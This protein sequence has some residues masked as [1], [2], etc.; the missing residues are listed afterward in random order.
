MIGIYKI[1]N[2]ING[3][4]YIGQS[5]NIEQRF[6]N[7]RNNTKNQ[8]LKNAIKKYGL[9]N[10]E[11]CV[12][13]EIDLD[14][15]TQRKMD[16][17]ENIYIQTYDSSNNKKGYNKKSGGSNGKPTE[18]TK[19]KMR[20]NHTD[21]SGNKNPMYG[22]S[23][24]FAPWYGRK[25]TEEEKLKISLSNKGKHFNNGKPMLN[26]KHTQETKN[27]ISLINKG[28]KHPETSKKIICITT[29]EVFNSITDG[30]NKYKIDIS[31]LAKHCK[32]RNN[33]CGKNENGEKL[34]WKYL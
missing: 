28:R 1:T 29:G 3:K 19:I 15:L 20:E 23:K 24:E 14:M 17:Y 31:T 13:K 30:A 9:N 18:E 32:G 25:H 12:L 6:K 10:F 5:W 22:K 34:S 16:L 33:Y 4:I 8:H 21:F 2:S 11:F 26:K 27:K 7:H